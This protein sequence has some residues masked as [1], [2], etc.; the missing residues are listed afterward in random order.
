MVAYRTA[1]KDYE[2]DDMAEMYASKDIIPQDVPCPGVD[3]T[4]RGLR[5]AWGWSALILWQKHKRLKLSRSSTCCTPERSPLPP[6]DF[7]ALHRCA[8]DVF[9]L[10]GRY[11]EAVDYRTE[12]ALASS[13]PHH[14]LFIADDNHVFS[15]LSTGG[16]FQKAHQ[17]LLCSGNTVAILRNGGA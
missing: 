2:V 16:G 17:Q 8:A 11:D 15:A 14:F 6:F 13:Y 7:A 10:A 3:R 12:I 4:E 5:Q 1:R 9:L